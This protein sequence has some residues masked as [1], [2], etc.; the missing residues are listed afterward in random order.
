MAHSVDFLLVLPTIVLFSQL[1]KPVDTLSCETIVLIRIT[2]D[3]YDALRLHNEELTPLLVVPVLIVETHIFLTT[4][5]SNHNTV[6]VHH[7]NRATAI[8][9][10]ITPRHT[11]V[12][13]VI[14][15]GH[16]H[17]V[18]RVDR[19][20]KLAFQ[21]LLVQY[22]GMAKTELLKALN[23]VRSRNLTKNLHRLTTTLYLNRLAAIRHIHS[24]AVAFVNILRKTVRCEEV[25]NSPAIHAHIAPVHINSTVHVVVERTHRLLVT[26]VV[27]QVADFTLHIA[28]FLSDSDFLRDDEVLA[29]HLEKTHLLRIPV[30]KYILKGGSGAA[31][32]YFVEC[33]VRNPR[34]NKFLIGSRQHFVIQHSIYLTFFFFLYLTYI[35]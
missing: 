20:T 28:N 11:R 12:P 1:A 3:A 18:H 14:I 16:S 19:K 32:I 30:A 26:S 22:A 6:G 8:A 17:I 25:H 24:K 35:L 13:V 34:F 10:T 5:V 27:E 7:L 9:T 2:L 4:E 29:K 23:L 31:A 33:V 21:H 15:V